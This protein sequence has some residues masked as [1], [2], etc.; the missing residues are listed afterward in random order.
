MNTLL[1]ADEMY[2]D[3]GKNGEIKRH[4][5]VTS[6]DGLHLAT[7]AAAAAADDDDDDDN[8]VVLLL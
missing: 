6:L 2:V 4:E 8:D 1:S 5:D 7:A 3:Q